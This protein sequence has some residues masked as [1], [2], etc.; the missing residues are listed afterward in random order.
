M[1]E[2]SIVGLIVFYLAIIFVVFSLFQSWRTTTMNT[3]EIRDKLLAA[4]KK[5]FELDKPC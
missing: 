5:Y 3:T 1:N 2:E 4:S